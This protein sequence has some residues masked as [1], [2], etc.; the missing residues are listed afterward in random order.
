MSADNGGCEPSGS[1][2]FPL[3]GGKRSLWEGGIRGAGFLSGPLLKNPGTVNKQLIHVTDWFPTLLSLAG[4]KE[5]LSQL[6]GYN[7]WQTI[8]SVLNDLLLYK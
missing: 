8:R 1:S 2:N 4:S 3:K 7:L 6:D 5:T